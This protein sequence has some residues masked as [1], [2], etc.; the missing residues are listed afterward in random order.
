MDSRAETPLR[1]VAFN[2]EILKAPGVRQGE[3]SKYRFDHAR[4]RHLERV[5][6]VIE[7]LDPDI[8]NLEEVIS[9]ESIDGLVDILHAKGL[10]DYRGYHVENND[11]FTGMD[12]ALISK[13]TPDEVDGA[14]IQ[15]I[16]SEDDDPTWRQAFSFTGYDGR[17]QNKTT[18]LSRN[19]L[20][21][22]TVSGHKLGFLGL[23]LKSNPSDQY[24]NAKR[25]AQADV[26]Q[27]VVRAKV[28]RLGYLPIVLG[29]LNDY[30]PDVA[31]RDEERSTKTRVLRAIK[32]FD[33]KSEGNELVNAARWIPRQQDRYTSHWDWNENG[34]RDPEDVFTMIDH[35]LLP[36][37]LE[38]CI[39]RVFIFR[40]VGLETTDHFPVVVDLLLPDKQPNGAATTA[41]TAESAE[42]AAH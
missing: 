20:Y 14:L 23:H 16:N 34:A 17:Q 7:A 15:T 26:V 32:D 12:V 27:R 42:T 10:T 6:E 25:S 5:A 35:V 1:V 11:S 39:E 41:V 24:A 19:A 13:I 9:R 3:L 30:D 36:K 21:Y 29:D 8:L 28:T 2:V 31:D 18:S 33:P 4:R 38:P 22:V 40:G 37:Q